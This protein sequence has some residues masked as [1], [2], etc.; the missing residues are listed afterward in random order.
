VST[1]SK[2]SKAVSNLAVKAEKAGAAAHN[3][4]KL[5]EATPHCAEAAH[6]TVD[7][8]KREL[9]VKKYSEIEG[10]LGRPSHV[11]MKFHNALGMLKKSDFLD[12]K[13]KDATTFITD[14]AYVPTPEELKAGL[15][16]HIRSEVE[17]NLTEHEQKRRQNQLDALMK[18]KANAAKLVFD[19]IKKRVE[20]DS[21]LKKND[22]VLHQ[23]YAEIHVPKEGQITLPPRLSG[24]GDML[25]LLAN[26]VQVSL[27]FQ[28]IVQQAAKS[29]TIMKMVAP[30]LNERGASFP[31]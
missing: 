26:A 9:K 23:I 8:L 20:G 7:V 24:G 10:E 30:L 12:V 19:F 4:A 22:Q 13:R 11:N 31:P 3:G 6:E 18:P 27:I 28:M 16:D 5:A 17:R 1:E 2:V 25:S 21:E 14:L 15:K 29:T